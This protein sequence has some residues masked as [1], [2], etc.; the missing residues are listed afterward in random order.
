MPESETG[1]DEPAE[2]EEGEP[3]A[4]DDNTSEKTE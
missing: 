2:G 3:A 1:S 4:K